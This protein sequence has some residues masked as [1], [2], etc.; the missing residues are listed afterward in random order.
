[1]F[2]EKNFVRNTNETGPTI[3]SPEISNFPNKMDGKIKI[4][5]KTFNFYHFL[6]YRRR[7]IGTSRYNM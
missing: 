6:T 5:L 4:L 3:I 2:F 7:N 1:M